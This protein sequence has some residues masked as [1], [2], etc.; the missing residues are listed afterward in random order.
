M[1]EISTTYQNHRP[2]RIALAHDHLAQ[3]GGAERVLKAFKEIYPE[4]P[5]FTLLFDRKNTN[6]FFRSAGV[7]TSFLQKMPLGVARYQWYLSLMPLATESQNLMNYDLVISS[8]SSFAKGVITNPAGAHIC[9]CHTPTRYLWSNSHEYLQD[10]R[11]NFI[12]KKF[13]PATLKKLR[14]WDQLAAERVD[15]FIANSQNVRQRILKYYKRDSEVIYPPVETE[16]FFVSP[17]PKKF[18]LAGGRLVPYKKIDL[19]VRAFTRLGAPLKIFGVGSEM[20]ALKKLAEEGK[21]NIEFLGKISDQQ[22]RWLF[23]NCLAYINPQEEDFGITAVEAMAAGRPVIAYCAGGATETIKEGETGEFFDDQW[24][25]DIA[26]KV[27]RFDSTKYDA[28]KIRSHAQNFSA[29]KFKEKMK[30]FVDNIVRQKIS[31]S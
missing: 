31:T 23:A 7:R 26:D 25:E 27:I 10:I 17:Y 5:I 14:L 9:Y 22:K 15:Y 24:W 30:N 21:G 8:A 20:K 3:D 18:F 1:T 13:L 4:A 6:D 28:E 2:V 12:V 11:V 16:K 29:D 19:V